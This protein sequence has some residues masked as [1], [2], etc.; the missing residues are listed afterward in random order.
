[1]KTFKCV[2]LYCKYIYVEVIFSVGNCPNRCQVLMV[3]I[4]ESCFKNIWKLF[5]IEIKF[6]YLIQNNIFSLHGHHTQIHLLSQLSNY[7]AFLQIARVVTNE[8]NWW[9]CNAT[10]VQTQSGAIIW[11]ISCQFLCLFC[12]IWFCHIN[13]GKFL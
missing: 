2:K 13:F 9:T 1:M 4:F 11:K 8:I 10:N 5:K 6:S 7:I 3:M 12:R